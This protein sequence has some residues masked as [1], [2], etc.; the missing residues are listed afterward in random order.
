[1]PGTYSPPTWAHY[2]II[3]KAAK[4]F[5]KETLYIVCSVNP[6]KKLWFTPEECKTIWEKSF[7]LPANVKVATLEEMLTVDFDYSKVIMIRGARNS[8]ESFE[9]EA[10]V[11]LLNTQQYGIT[12]F[13]HIVGDE[14][15]AHISSSK[16]RELAT[17]LKLE[18]LSKYVPP[19]VISKLLEKVL[20]INNLFLV[21]GKSGGGKSTYLKMIVSD[22]PQ[23][24]HINT[25]EFNKKL[26]PLLKE[27]FPNQNLIQVAIENEEEFLEI[28][29]IPWMSLLKENLQ[30]LPE[31]SNVYVEIPYGLQDT[32]RFWN[33]LGGKIVYIGPKENEDKIVENRN[34]KRGTE[35]LLPL[36]QTIP[37][38]NETIKIADK[39]NLQLTQINTGGNLKNLK[40]N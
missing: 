20:G 33:Y 30:N 5:S 6:E 39:F 16:V 19:M 34:K 9:E 14:K 25:D 28:I 24:V 11:M 27:K 29:R 32:K 8:K 10:D 40:I 12:N 26:K 1:M 15:Y 13:I 21:V 4:M 22:N 7:D 38:W 3:K 37:G 31:N 18:E 35:H 17:E 2:W 36:A 23:N